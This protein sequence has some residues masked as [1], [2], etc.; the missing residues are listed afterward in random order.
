MHHY[1]FLL[2]SE[3]LLWSCECAKHAREALILFGTML[4]FYLVRVLPS[5][6]AILPVNPT[7]LPSVSNVL[8]IVDTQ[9]Y[10]RCKV[11][12][13]RFLMSFPDDLISSSLVNTNKIVFAILQFTKAEVK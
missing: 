2:L 12:G 11:F 9:N 4:R 6:T 10:F 8:V 13:C 7:F 1:V 5:K 3:I